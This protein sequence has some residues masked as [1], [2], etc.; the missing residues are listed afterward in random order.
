MHPRGDAPEFQ[1]L[2]GNSKRQK[3]ESVL[4][5]QIGKGGKF[6]IIFITNSNCR[7]ASSI[8]AVGHNKGFHACKS[9]WM[10]NNFFDFQ[11]WGTKASEV[12]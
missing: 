3:K 10:Q 7:S 6:P 4:E 1:R 11:I 5:L 9:L 8:P 2:S 12:Q